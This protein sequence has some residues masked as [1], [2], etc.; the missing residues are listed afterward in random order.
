MNQA[1][2]EGYSNSQLPIT[3]EDQ[4]NQDARSGR[5]RSTHRDPGALARRNLLVSL[6]PHSTMP[7]TT[8]TAYEMPYSTH[9]H[10]HTYTKVPTGSAVM[11]SMLYSQ[12]TLTGKEKINI[13]RQP[14]EA[15][16]EGRRT[17]SRAGGLA[18]VAPFPHPAR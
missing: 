7:Q 3:S 17:R 16:S 10:T 6:V 9:T 11:S 2:L 18:G 4:L 14:E 8:M 5:E 15:R 13:D 12:E 1:N